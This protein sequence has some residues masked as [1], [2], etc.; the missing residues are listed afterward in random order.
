[1]FR[2]YPRNLARF[3]TP[4]PRHLLQSANHLCEL[5]LTDSLA[6]GILPPV[7]L[8]AGNWSAYLRR[9]TADPAARILL[10]VGG[11]NPSECRTR[12]DIQHRQGRSDAESYRH[13]LALLD[14]W[15]AA[16][17]AVP[18]PALHLDRADWANMGEGRYKRITHREPG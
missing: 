7:T 5:R 18:E 17:V 1:M 3:C 14:Q 4:F 6:P 15:G 16:W 11:L 10:R 8:R 13:R 2:K 9:H 12:L